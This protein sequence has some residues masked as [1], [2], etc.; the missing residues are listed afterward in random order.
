MLPAAAQV[1]REEAAVGGTNAQRVPGSARLE[2]LRLR[3][4]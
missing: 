3:E 1:G 2:R 4:R